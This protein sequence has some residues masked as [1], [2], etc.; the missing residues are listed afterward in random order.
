LYAGAAAIGGTPA[1]GRLKLLDT[2]PPAASTPSPRRT[3][4]ERAWLLLA[5]LL[6]A[7]L[8]GWQRWQD[9]QAIDLAERERLRVQIR[10]IDANLT[11]QFVSVHMVLRGLRADLAGGP[12]GARLPNVARHM[13][14]LCDAMPGVRSL[15]WLDAHGR[16]LAASAPELQ[17]HD[18]SGQDDFRRIVQ[19]PEA[20]RLV[21]SEPFRGPGGIY[22]VNL[23]MAMLGPKGE[24]AGLVAATL[25]PPYFDTVLSSA[26]YARDMRASVAHGNGRL[27]L[28][29]P[30][31]RNTQG[32]NLNNPASMFSRHR[33]SGQLETVFNGRLLSSGEDR[34]MAQRSFRPDEVPMEP[35]LV[36]GISR[37]TATVFADWQRRAFTDVVLFVLAAVAAWWMLCALQR[38]RQQLEQLAVQAAQQ[39][40]ADGE[41]V[42]LALRG[43]DLALWDAHIPSRTGVVNE[44][45]YSMLGYAPHE[46]AADESGWAAL[47]HPED[48]ERVIAAQEAHVRGETEAYEA[49]YRL[50]HRD[51]RWVWVL[52]RARV[53]ERD[54]AGNALRMV[55]THMDITERMAAEDALRRNEQSLAITLHSI[56]DAVIAT[57]PQG[58]VTR[59]NATAERMTGWPAVE[60]L[61]RPLG[62]LFRIRNAQ[63]GEPAQD[64]VAQV[65]ARGDIVGLANDT[66]LLARDGR[67]Y[68]IADSAA[69]IRAAAPDGLGE[70]LGVVLVFSDVTERYRMLQALREREEQLERVTA[71]MPGPVAR[72]DREGRY[73]YTNATCERWFGRP[74]AMV[75]GRNWR[76][77]Y[78]PEVQ[79]VIEPEML[80]AL[81]GQGRSFDVSLPTLMGPREAMV[82]LVPDHDDSGAVCGCFVVVNDIT[83]R[84]QAQKALQRS[85]NQLRMASRM[86]RLG[87]WRRD[88]HTGQVTLSPE[89][90]VIMELE[91]DH[92]PEAGGGVA[93]VD[94]AHRPALQQRLDACVAQGQP[95]DIEV[96][97]RSQRG[98]ALHLRLLGEP[99]RDAEGRIVA[100]QGAVLDLTE[101][102]QA[103]LQLQALE[104]QHRTLERQLRE[105]QKMESIGTLAG[106]IAHDFN[107]ILPAILGNVA[108]ARA[109]LQDLPARHAVLQS[110][111]QINTAAL[112]ARNLVQQILTFSRRQPNALQAQPLRPVVEETLALLRATLPAGVRLETQ[113]AE[114]SLVVEADATQMQQVLMNLC[115]NAWHALPEG[116]GRIVVGLRGLAADAAAALALP[117]VPPG[118]CVHLWVQDNG[119][120]MDEALR[121][122]IFDPF[123]TTKPV[124]HGTGL[125]LSVVHG[126]VRGH[127]GAIVVDSAPGQGS[128]F[129]LYLPMQPM[130]E[131]RRG[132]GATGVPAAQGQGQHVLYVD[133]DEVMVVLV[134]RLLEHAGYRVSTAGTAAQALALVQADPAAVDLV[135]TDYN[136]PEM[137]GLDLARALRALKPGMPLIISSGYLTDAL[138]Q[139]AKALGVRSLLRKENTLERLAGLVQEALATAP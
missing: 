108:L 99:V 137:S 38:R 73:L 133:D 48:R 12:E 94:D 114:E 46:V 126:I 100:L 56:G 74:A 31:N 4:R 61:G 51:G 128:T 34:L 58:R 24:F 39:R 26:L 101:W 106:G 29:H 19:R 116:Q 59:I 86:A 111:E 71:A 83:E 70:I 84:K 49:I 14:A 78:P 75:L 112:R 139:Q 2:P 135:V 138:R 120:G 55:G 121:E 65:L 85:E 42:A 20:E 72:L 110:L 92:K 41:R 91:P 23:S 102:H 8:L 68:Q 52:D 81:A 80:Q 132:A 119:I 50:R 66:V 21:V 44:R 96:D 33:A 123:F 5:L 82:S 37:D 62:E 64:P 40:A 125:G 18:F 30:G 7:L 115:T 27:I 109:D 54:A 97:A 95:F 77:V 118:P 22:S 89:L 15:H 16:V 122:R 10:A 3:W 25:D 13:A 60:A 103:R 67:E 93:L 53:V 90:M 88:L 35:L 105:S 28:A 136:M 32:I 69:P 117:E 79:A 130:P 131:S 76:E 104:E 113:L 87:G 11:R 17:G 1:D 107:N 45:W 124:G 134:Q 127:R 129:H 6:L 9:H 57:D 98:R 47:V 63:T 43:G 36:L